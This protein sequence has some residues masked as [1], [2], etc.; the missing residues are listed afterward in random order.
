LHENRLR[1]VTCIRAQE[2][3]TEVN[4]VATIRASSGP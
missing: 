1:V 3:K 4:S 2:G